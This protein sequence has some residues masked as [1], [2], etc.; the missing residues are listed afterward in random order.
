MSYFSSLEN[1]HP[2]KLTQALHDMQ[3]QNQ[4]CDITINVSGTSF[5]AHK[6]VLAA[7][8]PYFMAMFT[9]GFKESNESEISVDANP[10]I[11]KYLLEFAYSGKMT[12]KLETAADLLEMTNFMQFTDA[13]EYCKSEA[14]RIIPWRSD[15]TREVSIDA[16]CKIYQVAKSYDD[17]QSLADQ[18]KT[19]MCKH[20][21]RLK[22][23]DVF[24]QS[25]SEDFLKQFLK[26]ADL[27]SKDEEEE[28]SQ[29]VDDYWVKNSTPF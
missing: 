28:V 20:F 14:S 22:T 4:L 17:L 3:K 6:A 23:S 21:Q 15:Q 25:F 2:R 5:H 1:Q 7:S 10:E 8:S 16:V 12:C 18:T 26:R 13:F 11:F 24:L 29:E 19:Y 27:A 9:S